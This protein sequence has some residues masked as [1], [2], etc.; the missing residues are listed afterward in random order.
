MHTS[1]D[2]DTDIQCEGINI[3]S[4]YMVKMLAINI[5]KK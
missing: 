5:D 1:K 3:K 4:E 2:I